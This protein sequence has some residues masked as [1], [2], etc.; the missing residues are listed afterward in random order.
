M[1]EPLRRRVVTAGLPGRRRARRHRHRR[2]RPGHPGQRRQPDRRRSRRTSRT[3]PPSRSTPTTRTS[4]PP[5][6]ND[7]IDMEACNAG[8]DDDCPFTPGVGVSGIY[9]SRTSGSS[10]T[11]PTYTGLTAPRLPRRGRRRRPGVHAHARARS[12]RC[13]TTTPPASSPTATRRWPS[14]PS[15]A[16]NGTFSWANGS[17]LYY[18]NLASAVPGASPFKGS[19]AIAVLAHRRRRGDLERPVHRQPPERGA[20]LRQGADLGRQ[21]GVEPVL[22]PRLRVLRQLPREREGLHEPA[23]RGPDLARRRDDVGPEA[24]DAGDEQH[25]A[26]ATASAARAARCARTRPGKV[27]VFVFQFGFSA[28]T[29]APGRIQMITSDDGGAHFSRP[30]NVVTA[31]DT[32]NYVEPSIGRCVEDGVGGARSDLSPAPSVDIAN[33]APSGTDATNRLVMSWVDGRAGL[34]HEQVLF[35]T[36]GQGGTSW[37]APAAVQQGD[38]PRLL[39]RAGDLARRARGVARLQRVHHAVPDERDRPRQRPAAHRRRAPRGRDRGR[40]GGVQH[41][42]P[43]RHGR[44]ARLVA[45]RPRRGVPGRLRLRRGDADV[46]HRRLERPAPRGGLRR[47]GPLPPGPARRGGGHRP[48]DR[49]AGGA[50]RASPPAR[51]RRRTRARRS[52]PTSSRS[53]RPRSATRTS[54][55]AAGP[56]ARTPGREGARRRAPLPA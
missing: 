24:G 13:R 26:A 33:G 5:D 25:A 40:R 17:R 54:T 47:R 31:F 20:V 22:R 32:C 36:S 49:R 10:W 14:G 18:A 30:V 50:A 19:E 42:P 15:R 9:L 29:A 37:T 21:R 56:T 38:R 8:P 4:S 16:A 2:R 53:A 48:A 55:G 28:T 51:R 3:S 7:E 45:E 46:R 6:S 12:A 43:R 34:N 35:S 27:Y 11:Q 41:G 52:R 44:C 1:I 39:L 23:A